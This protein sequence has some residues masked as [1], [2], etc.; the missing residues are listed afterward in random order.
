MAKEFAKAF[1]NSKKWRMCRD[2]YIADRMMI[3]GGLCEQCRENPGYIVH[4]EIV[5]TEDNIS[6]AEISLNHK[7][8]KYVCKDCHD[9]YDGHG[10]NKGAK[11]LCIFDSVGQ[12]ISLR[13]ID[14]AGRKVIPP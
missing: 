2:S 12:P 14:K 6:N 3:D 10:L 4:H 13:E 9:M 11:P 8:F 7:W 5:L 1:Y